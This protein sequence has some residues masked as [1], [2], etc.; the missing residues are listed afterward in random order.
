MEIFY[1]E[2]DVTVYW[3]DMNDWVYVDWRNI[4]SDRSVKKGCEEILTLLSHKQCAHVLNDNRSVIG[5]WNTAAQWVAEDWFPR[6]LSAG[7]KKFAWIQ[8][9]NLLSKFAA[10]QSTASNQVTDA[11]HLFDDEESAI[12]WLNKS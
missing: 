2:E 11:I 6:M 4:P 5:P 1:E 9:P 3:D 7:M 12:N 10:R 8:S